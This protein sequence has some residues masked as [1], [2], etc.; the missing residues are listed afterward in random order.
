LLPSW[1]LRYGTPIIPSSARIFLDKP[2]NI[3]TQSK[4]PLMNPLVLS[5][6][7]IQTQSSPN[8]TFY[9]KTVSASDG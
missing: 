2:T 5:I 1:L 8:G 4:F 6:G 9:S 7:S 3:V